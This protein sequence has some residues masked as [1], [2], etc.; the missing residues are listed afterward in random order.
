MPILG[1][2]GLGKSTLAFSALCQDHVVQHFGARRVSI[3]C[4]GIHTRQALVIHLAYTLGLTLDGDIEANL[5]TELDREP[6][7]LLLDNIGTTWRADIEA[8]TDFLTAVAALPR[9]ALLITMRGPEPPYGIPWHDAFDLAPL[10]LDEARQLFLA[11]A[12]DHYAAD[13][14]LDDLVGQ[15]DGMPLQLA[16]LAYLAAGTPSLTNLCEDWQEVYAQETSPLTLLERALELSLNGPRMTKD[17]R[18]LLS[19]WALLPNGI[20]HVD[21]P[22][23]LPDASEQGL[24]VLRETGLTHDDGK[25][26]RVARSIR[27]FMQQ[28]HPSSMEELGHMADYYLRLVETHGPNATT[29]VGQEDFDRVL[30]EVA[31]AETMMLLGLQQLDTEHVAQAASI[32]VAFCESVG[33]GITPT[34]ERVQRLANASDTLERE[35]SCIKIL[36]DLALEKHD[37]PGAI[38]RYEEALALYRQAA[39]PLGEGNCLKGLGDIALHQGEYQQAS[40][41]YEQALPLLEQARYPL[42]EANCRKSLGDVALHLGDYQQAQT[43]YEAALPLYHLVESL[44][45]EANCIRALGDLAMQH[46]DHTKAREQ[47]EYAL[48][49]YSR[50]PEPYSIGGTHRRLAR[51]ALSPEAVRQHIR[52]AREVWEIIERADLVNELMA[53][54]GQSA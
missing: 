52:E 22:H 1:A 31:N 14:Q 54:F 39:S 11:L 18:Q 48:D 25:R 50:I 23:V 12:G 5:L 4:D 24:S 21:A 27:E 41:H 3:H 33:L 43:Q 2:P 32:L 51:L 28:R 53:E 16:L 19:L 46:D 7:A 42:R 29:A 44:L 13:P 40:R 47:Y 37:Y 49:I 26:L 34:L 15:Q 38:A 9:V 20:A 45:G 36:G 35:A 30:P 6:I 17:A 10:H 8:V